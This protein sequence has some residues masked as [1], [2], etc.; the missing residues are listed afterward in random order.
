MQKL[1]EHVTLAA[2]CAAFVYFVRWTWHDV[3]REKR[4]EVTDEMIADAFE[5][6]VMSN[7]DNEF[8]KVDWED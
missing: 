6:D 8:D 2:A 7:F 3:K 1:I 4:P 5:R